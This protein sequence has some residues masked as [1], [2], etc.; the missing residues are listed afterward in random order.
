VLFALPILV[1]IGSLYLNPNYG[2]VLLEDPKG[3]LMLL[4]AGGMQLMGLAMI[5]WIVNI[6]V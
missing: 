1:F 2:S 6:K 4:I 5:R 3:K